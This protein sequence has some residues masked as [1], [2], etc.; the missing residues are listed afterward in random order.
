MWKLL[1]PLLA[2]V[3][4]ITPTDTPTALPIQQEGS[5][6]TIPPSARALDFQQAFETMRK[7]K[8]TGKVYFQL[9]DGT[10]IANIIDMTLMSN[11][12]LILFRFNSPQGIR[13]QVVKVE[14][15]DN[16]LY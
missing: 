15:I 4:T 13:F 16:I 6:M 10:T 11:S 7:E 14:D 3:Q 12:T 1:M 5:I 2:S 9:I 8:S